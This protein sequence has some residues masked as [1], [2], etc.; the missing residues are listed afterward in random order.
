MAFTLK[1]CRS[2]AT[3]RSSCRSSVQLA[4]SSMMSRISRFS[5]SSMKDPELFQNVRFVDAARNS[6]TQAKDSA[7]ALLKS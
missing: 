1:R 5:T 4:R 6:L 7:A 3:S 2:E